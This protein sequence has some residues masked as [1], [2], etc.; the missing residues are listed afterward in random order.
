[1]APF[2]IER[3]GVNFRKKWTRAQLQYKVLSASFFQDLLLE[4]GRLFEL[5]PIVL[6]TGVE[7]MRL[8]LLSDC[9]PL[10]LGDQLLRVGDID[11]RSVSSLDVAVGLLQDYAQLV[12]PSD[13]VRIKYFR[14]VGSTMPLILFSSS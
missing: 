2:N 5:R 12:S 10:L 14:K 8:T 9:A 4:A 1:M 11:L 13:F 6:K 7:L 3:A